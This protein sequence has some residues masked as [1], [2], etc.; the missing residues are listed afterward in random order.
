MTQYSKATPNAFSI[1]PSTDNT[2]FDFRHNYTAM[3]WIEKSGMI[4]GRHGGAVWQINEHDFLLVG[5][6]LRNI[7]N[8]LN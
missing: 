8:M 7:L 6:V 1:K 4:E 5:N 3:E 2:E